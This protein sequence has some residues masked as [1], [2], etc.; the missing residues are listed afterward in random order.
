V[1]GVLA[2]VT[3]YVA[4]NGHT[5]HRAGGRPTRAPSEGPLVPGSRPTPAPA[6]NAVPVPAAGAYVGAW[7]KPARNTDS[8]RIS[9]AADFQAQLGRRLDIVQDYRTWEQDFPSEF[10]TAIAQSGAYPL[11]SWA[12]TDTRVIASGT[13]DNAIR[14][15]AR[16]VKKFGSPIL[17]RWRWEMD[18]ANLQSEIHGPAEYIAAWERIRAVFDSEKVTNV[19][20]VWCPLAEGFADGD[21]QRYYPGDAQVDWV[22]ADA[23]SVT[24]DEPLASVTKPFLEW[25]A[26]RG[27]P[28]M[29][30]EFGTQAGRP[31]QRAAWIAGVGLLARENPAIKAL[32]YFDANVDRDGRARQWSLREVPGDIAAFGKLATQPYFNPAKV[33]VRR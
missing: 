9:A 10:E 27:K 5:S 18:R 30:A 16:E 26:K 14:L 3:T 19:S 33:P 8:G 21:A 28:V 1:A 11:I 22:C 31:A 7:V 13:Y 29:I 25:A 32:V 23:Y 2:V 6:V 15:K 12:G 24:P 20:W 17:L 4:L